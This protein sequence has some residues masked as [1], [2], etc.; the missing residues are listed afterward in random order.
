[1]D[2]TGSGR[3]RP[4]SREE[5]RAAIAHATIPL[6][7]Q[8][9]AQVSTRQIAIAA[10]VAEGTL[11]RA[12]DD[13]VELLTAAAER[14][15]DP[16]ARVAEIDALPA[17]ADLAAELVQVGQVIAEGGHRVRRV[18]LAVHGVLASEEGQ[19]AAAVRA[20][21]G[22]DVFGRPVAGHAPRA[23][24]AP[25]V[26][27]PASPTGATGATGPTVPAGA[28]HGRL[29]GPPGRDARF[30]A[31]TE[32]RA[33]VARR[34]EPYRAELRVDPERLAHLL[35]ATLM[36]QG[37]PVLPDDDQ[38]ALEDLVDVLLRGVARTGPGTGPGT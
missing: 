10:G 32:V 36:G 5:R 16:T 30:R 28:L 21:R 27:G 2:G 29:H 3:A 31:M 14:A 26:R 37:P 22:V 38:I 25:A 7:E 18:M 19:R 6:L 17:A 23:A 33:A 24:D 1:M 13:K 34:L 8:H 35:L 4:M 12:F 15:L 9:G 20:A 11:F